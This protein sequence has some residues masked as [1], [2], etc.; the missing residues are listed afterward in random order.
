MCLQGGPRVKR[1]RAKHSP[2][3]AH[4]T[5]TH[6][7]SHPPPF[8]SSTPS[9]MPCPSLSPITPS[10]PTPSLP[11]PLSQHT[12]SLSSHPAPIAPNPTPKSASF[13][14][15]LYPTPQFAH[16][17]PALGQMTVCAPELPI[18]SPVPL[19][20]EATRLARRALE[21]PSASCDEVCV[22]LSVK[23]YCFC[24]RI[25]MCSHVYVVCPFCVRVYVCA[26][27]FCVV[28]WL[29]TLL[30]LLVFS[31]LCSEWRK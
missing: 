15:A 8:S 23:C 31:R 30:Y 13:R 21:T 28:S 26:C 5:N 11:L 18:I 7:P 16:A 27:V 10:L 3:A 29:C 4:N 12:P 2:R 22:F 17:P 20:A 1:K 14:A 24:V 25:C 6:A 19:P 9:L